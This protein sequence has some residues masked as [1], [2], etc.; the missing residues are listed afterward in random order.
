MESKFRAFQLDSAGSLF[1]YYKPNYYTLIEARLPKGGIEVLKEDLTIHGKTKVDTLHITSWDT[2]HC[3]F[4]DLVQIINQLRPSRIEAPG[5]LPE[6]D[7]AK[8]CRDVLLKY[9]DIHQKY[10][11]N[12]QLIDESFI[13]KLTPAKKLDTNDIIYPSKFNCD[14]KNDMSLI[15]LFRSEG[16]NVISLGDCES[17]EVANNLIRRPIFKSEIDVLILPHHG[18]NNGFMSGAFLDVVKPKLAVCSSNFDNHYDHPRQ[19][20]RDMLRARKI[21]LMTTKRGDVVV[22]QQKGLTTAVAESLQSDNTFVEREVKF[23]PK[24]HWQ[25]YIKKLAA[26]IKAKKT[27]QS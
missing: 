12:V 9:D 25:N 17:E 3:C 16:F 26:F 11:L 20:I 23:V 19:E 10:I 24:K 21:P 4:D 1:S 7:S 13:S 15:K 18:A 6:S 8:M 5:Y 27:T 2:D 14:N 22:S